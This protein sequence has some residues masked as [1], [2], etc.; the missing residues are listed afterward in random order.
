MA[1]NALLGDKVLPSGRGHTTSCFVQVEKSETGKKYL[2]T[3][4]APDTHQSIQVRQTDASQ[5]K[6]K[7][8]YILYFN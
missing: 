3:P 4:E 1:I 2:L 5:I 6:R 8:C 7:H